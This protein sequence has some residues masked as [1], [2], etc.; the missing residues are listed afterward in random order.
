MMIGVKTSLFYPAS[1]LERS[2]SF[3][4]FQWANPAWWI[5]TLIAPQFRWDALYHYLDITIHD[6][7]PINGATAFQPLFPW[8]ARGLYLL[9]M[10]PFVSLFLVSTVC[11]LAFLVAFYK[12]AQMDLSAEDAS[13]STILIVTSPIAFVLFIPYT[14]SLFLLLCVLCF[15][16]MRHKRWWLAGLAA[17]LATLTKQAGVFLVFP[18]IMEI[19]ADMAERHLRFK[20]VW[21]VWLSLLPVPIAALGWILYRSYVIEGAFPPYTGFANFLLSMMV[22]THTGGMVAS[23]PLIVWPWDVIIDAIRTAVTQ[24][25][26]RL[27]TVINLG[28]F[29]LVAFGIGATW[30]RMR[31]GYQLFSLAIMVFTLLDFSV[32]LTAIPVESLFRHAYIAFPRFIVLPKILT[33]KWSRLLYPSLSLILFFVLLYSYGMEG[34]IV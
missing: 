21:K 13:Y 17:G 10:D 3:W 1:S 11:T 15:Y 6:Y 8:L 22:S 19:S 7:N 27:D 20:A 26:T 4:S 16:Y 29:F 14:E 31:Q 12:L 5:R 24:P 25:R 28:G 18:M 2:I 34:W 33:G 9:G 30:S 32:N 23:R